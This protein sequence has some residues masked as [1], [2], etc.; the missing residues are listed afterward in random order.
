MMHR[1]HLP[2]Q[3][4]TTPISSPPFFVRLGILMGLVCFAGLPL[5]ASNLAWAAPSAGKQAVEVT[6]PMMPTEKAKTQKT[7]QVAK[8]NKPDVVIPK[9]GKG[10]KKP[11]WGWGFGGY[12]MTGYRFNFND[13]KLLRLGDSD[14]FYVSRARMGLK[15]RVKDFRAVIS[16]DGIFDRRADPFDVSPSTRRLAVELRD[17]FL[18]YTHSS[19]FYISVGQNKVPFSMHADRSATE[20]KFINFPLIAVGEDIAFGYQVRPI[21][22]GRDIG[23]LL[24]FDR[25]FGL[26]HFRI[27][28]SVFN[29]N[30]PNRFGNDS[31]LPA[32]ATRFF[33]DIGSYFHIGGSFMFNQRRVGEEPNLFDESDLVFGADIGFKIAGFFLEGGF[34]ARQT[35]FLTTGQENDFAFGFRGDLGYKIPVINLEIVAR[36]EMYD[37]SSLFD[38]DMLLYITAGLNW[39][40]RIWRQHQ[41][42]LRLNY[43]AKLELNQNRALNNDQINLMIQYRY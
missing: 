30:G 15:L 19:G 8:I 43:I 12:I 42:V 31:D 3:L 26:A 22:P 34:A 24:G 7:T 41:L 18:N 37:P 10:K 17:A 27:E 1:N 20:E 33:L 23:V 40:Y 6:G 29:G 16:I 13:E 38:D 9:A 5:L 14:G 2:E 39:Y 21:I 25:T 36:V 28:A 35:T 32:V 11:I 4:P